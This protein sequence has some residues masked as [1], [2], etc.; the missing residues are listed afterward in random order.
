MLNVNQAGIFMHATQTDSFITFFV[1]LNI[2]IEKKYKTIKK[3][4]P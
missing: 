1:L 4:N 3:K 2:V